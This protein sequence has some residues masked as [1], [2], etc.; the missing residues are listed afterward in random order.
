M[1]SFPLGPRGGGSG[2]T[3]VLGAQVLVHPTAEPVGV[4][5]LQVLQHPEPPAIVEGHAHRL[6]HQRLGSEELQLQPFCHANA[7]GGFLG[8]SCL[9]RLGCHRLTEGGSRH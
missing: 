1:R 5:V 2:T 6:P 4:R 9:G 7:L 3:V 8:Q